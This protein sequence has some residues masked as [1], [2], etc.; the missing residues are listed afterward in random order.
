MFEDRRKLYLLIKKGEKKQNKKQT[1][2]IN[3]STVFNKKSL[4]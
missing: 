4:K 3:L 2:K 1:G